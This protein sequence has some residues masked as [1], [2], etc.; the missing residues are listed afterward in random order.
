MKAKRKRNAEKLTP[1]KIGTHLMVRVVN[2]Y[3]NQSVKCLPQEH[4]TMSW[5]KAQT[6]TRSIWS[7]SALTMRPPRL[8]YSSSKSFNF[9][10]FINRSE[11]DVDLRTLVYYYGIA[12]TGLEEWKWLFDKFMNTSEASE[13][14]KLMFALAGSRETWILNM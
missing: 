10:W 2:K 1:S 9:V 14:S 3:G 5:A 12:N 8:D 7:V 13:K 11:I 4:N 6:Q